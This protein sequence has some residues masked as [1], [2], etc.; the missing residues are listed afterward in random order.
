MIFFLF[1]S[2]SFFPLI[3]HFFLFSSSFFF[4]YH[5]FQFSSSSE[6]FKGKARCKRKICT[7][8][9]LYSQIPRLDVLHY[10]IVC[11]LP[12]YEQT[13]TNTHQNKHTQC[14]RRS[15]I[16]LKYMFVWQADITLW[17]ILLLCINLYCKCV[18]AI[19]ISS[20]NNNTHTHILFI[21]H[22]WVH[23]ISWPVN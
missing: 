4:P 9:N 18:N 2:S 17:L 7:R 16:D 12:S 21:C 20:I 1:L 19:Q 10:T 5:L 11:F 8:S 14:L 3:L 6:D 23:L 22:W 15:H 13:Y